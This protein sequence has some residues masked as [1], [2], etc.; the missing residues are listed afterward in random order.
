[1][2]GDAGAEA[3]D[4]VGS[5][6][7]ADEF[8]VAEGVEHSGVGGEVSAPTHAHGGEDGDGVVV[9]DASGIECGNETDGCTY[10]AQSSN[11]KAHEGTAFKA[12]EPVEYDINLVGQPGDDGHTFVGLAEVFA[13]LACGAEGEHHDDGGD[14]ENAGD[15]GD[16]DTDATLAAVEHGVE[17]AL[18]GVALALK[19]D[20]LL[21]AF[22]FGDGTVHLGITLEGELLHE[23]CGD[24]ASDDGAEETD[25]G[26]AAVAFASHEGD[27]D[28]SHAEGGAEVGERDELVFLEVAGKVVVFGQGDDGG[29]VG[30]EGHHGSQGCHAGQVVEGFHEWA[31]DVL[32]QA[33]DTELGEELGDGPHENADG[34]DVEHSLEQQLIGGL[35]EG[36]EHVG[37]GH[38]IGQ[39]A[40]E[41]KEEH[42][43]DERLEAAAGGEFQP[44]WL[45]VFLLLCFVVL[46]HL[47]RVEYRQE[48]VQQ[49]VM[50]FFHVFYF[51]KSLWKSIVQ[52]APRLTLI[53]RSTMSLLVAL[54]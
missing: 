13:V 7:F 48:S 2:G 20:V 39:E 16:T 28:E 47:E 21:G 8:A 54:V 46:E 4:G 12:E 33:H 34:H 26:S 32:H 37:K 9:D 23:A 38:L 24:D 45:V 52:V 40:K 6:G 10:G 51:L 19:G 22:L 44:T 27:D 29:V 5:D 36:V 3:A 42:E 30:E 41:S 17:E 31:E 35:H 11:G 43:E 15:D 53:E 18:E 49:V 14:A 50:L 25:E 1:M